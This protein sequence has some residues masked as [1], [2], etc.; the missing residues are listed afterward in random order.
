MGRFYLRVD[1]DKNQALW[2]NYATGLTGTEFGQYM[3]SLYGAALNWRSNASN[4]WGEARSQLRVFASEA[5]TAPGH[6]EFLGTGGSL[7]Y[8]RHTD[9]LPGSDQVVL[10]IRDATTGRTESR[11]VLER[12]ADYEIDELQG[13][14]LLTR[15]LNQITLNNMPSLTRLSPLDG[16]EQRLLVD[17]EWVPSGF[18]PDEVTAGVRGKHWFGDVLG[19]GLTHV[20]ENR[21]GQDYTLSA[22]DVTLQAGRGTYLKA[23]AARTEAHGAPVFFS[24]NGGLSFTQLNSTAPREGQA[25]SVEA[26]A[27]FR[28]LG[29]TRQDWSAGA[30]WRDVEAGYSVSRYDQGADIREVGAEVLGQVTSNLGIY[31]R[32]TRAD[33][34]SDSLRQAQLTAEWRLNDAA[35]L[36]GELRRI[37]E[38]RSSGDAAGTLG[39]IKYLQRFG[40]AL[41]LY[42]T[43][44]FTIDDDGGAY[45]DNNA[46]IVGGKYLFGNL[47]SVGGEISS[48][49]RGDAVT[50]TGEYRLATD[51]TLYGSYTWSTDSTAYDPLFNPR[52]QNGWTVGQ[53]WRLS[54][55][56]NM[57]NE[58]QY[59]KNASE[60]GLAHTF[61]MDFYPGIGWTSGFTLQHGE[62][63]TLAGG[64]VRRKA[65]SVNGGRTAVDTDW[66]SKLEWRRDSGAERRE[67]WVSTNR[68]TH[69]I[70][71][72]WR[73][74]ARFNYSHTQDEINAQ[75]DAKFIEG[76]VGFAWRPW[77]STRWAVFGR[78]TYLYDLSSLGQISEINYDQRSQVLSL[79][80]IYKL[81]QHWEFTAKAARREGEV[82][83]GRGSG[84]WFDSATTFV[85]GQVRYDLRQQWH[86][87][88]EYRWLDVADGGTRQ[89]FL[90]GLDRDINRNFR[91]GVG[92][93]FTDFSDDL[94]NFDYDHRGFFLNLTGV[95]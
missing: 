60:S 24:D 69:R 7:Y 64:Q 37:D 1:W 22:A 51:H 13:R 56:V 50:V 41:E 11:V 65:V 5:Q 47:S 80:G 28:E 86:A 67:Q 68:L 8:L 93:N 61:G 20:Q 63:E 66:N 94:T 79:E 73:I 27:N 82:R 43:G 95:Y 70:N 52:Q 74:A 16:L 91:I 29:W 48:G 75:A 83:F 45:A 4:A 76:N 38:R 26:R 10:E 88:A 18:N 54:N 92:Y 58:S 19:I 53:R 72:S 55:Q 25:R 85:S 77:D 35:T 40:S 78:Y 89:G 36:S 6:S 2:G 59:L 90:V 57:F 87:L 71:D 32:A 30:W 46:L 81:D 17:Y 12:G 9:I 62:L 21:A 84:A 31:L 44:Q 42:A 49:D 39:A 3:R 14:I 23:E 33:R 34:N 15:P